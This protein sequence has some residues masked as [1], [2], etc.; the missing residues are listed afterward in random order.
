MG[1][2][3]PY[4]DG[5][6]YGAVFRAVFFFL[7][8][9]F[10]MRSHPPSL[11]PLLALSLFLSFGAAFDQVNARANTPNTIAS[12]TSHGASITPTPSASISASI[13]G[14]AANTTTLQ[15]YSFSLE[16]T[17]P[18]AVPLSSIVS[19]ASS[20]P[21]TPLP[22]T[23]TAGSV[24]TYL[25]NAPPLPDISTLLPAN[26]PPL[27]K[28][29]PID[30]PEVQQWITE[31]QNT[32]VLI[33]DFQPNA[34]GGCPANPAA[35]SDPSRCWWTCGGCVRS[36]DVTD[37][38][39]HLEWGLTYDD[40]PAYHTPDLLDYL[41]QVNLKSTFFVVGSRV[42]SLPATLQYE[43]MNE[44][45]IAV[46]TWS[47]TALTTQTNEEI[48]AELGWSKK[49]IRDVLGVTPNLMRPPYGDID[50]RV[51]AI[52]IAMGLQP[53]IWSRV[54]ANMTFDTGDYYIAGG[55]TTVSEVLSNWET[56]VGNAETRQDGFIVLE[57]DLFQ[58]SVEV[59][60]GYILPDAIAHNFTI[61]PVI[62]CLGKTYNDAYIEL[63]DNSTNP[64]LISQS[65]AVT[66]TSKPTVQP[67]GTSKNS[68]SR[69]A[70]SGLALA[71]AATFVG[72]FA[73]IALVF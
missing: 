43:Y 41:N 59:A 9:H 60:T 19:N 49:V 54:S 42:I 31:V 35:A 4:A 29:P 16:S 14:T 69:Q 36:T 25:S 51:R 46:H 65:G 8:N 45:Q 48:I 5:V 22:A 10:L 55:L 26:Y 62:T 6:K 57:H 72:I 53:V 64:P 66:F 11:V 2:L 21:L 1:I 47:H 27:D 71:T 61:K 12:S 13:N 17:N 70:G 63:N 3:K 37:C 18:T 50:D 67:T 40:G 33:P 34:N 23:A 7:S 38:P 32:G 39:T 20:A 58:Q 52:S 68:G 73:G 44:H 30:T 24:P 15:T 28:P 56:I